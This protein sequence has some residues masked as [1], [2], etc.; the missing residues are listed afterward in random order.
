MAAIVASSSSMF[1]D[2]ASEDRAAPAT[3][4][5]P[6]EAQPGQQQE[7]QALHVSVAVADATAAAATGMG[8]VFVP[9][10][11]SIPDEEYDGMLLDWL[12]RQQRALGGDNA[13][14][15]LEEA[16]GEAGI[17]TVAVGESA[18]RLRA[19]QE[20]LRQYG[21]TGVPVVEFN[22]SDMGRALD[23]MHAYVLQCIELAL[24]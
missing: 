22:T 18:A 15:S 19:L 21:A 7:Q 16:G 4:A 24:N 8:P 2:R 11:L 3:P 9:I 5:K 13:A 20:H 23:A 10:C 14:S 6:Q 12:A 1:G 17:P